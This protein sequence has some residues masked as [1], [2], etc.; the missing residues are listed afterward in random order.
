M[1]KLVEAVEITGG[2]VVGDNDYGRQGSDGGKVVKTVRVFS[3]VPSV[4]PYLSQ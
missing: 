1:V 4:G 2:K 3:T